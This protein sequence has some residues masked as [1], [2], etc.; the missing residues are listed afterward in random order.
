MSASLNSLIQLIKTSNSIYLF[1]H[2]NGDGDCIGS[3]SALALSLRGIGK[4]CSVVISEDIPYNLD[5]LERGLYIKEPAES[6]ELG[7]LVD[8][9]S[10]NRIKPREQILLNCKSLACIDH[11]EFQESSIKFDAKFVD[12][13][14]AACAEIIYDII[15]ELEVPLDIPLAECIY[16]GIATDTGNFMHSNTSAKSHHIV[17]ELYNIDG[18]D[19]N[20]ICHLI[21]ERVPLKAFKLQGEILTNTEFSFDNQFAF[22]KVS[23]EQLTNSSVSF[24]ELE[25]IVGTLL[26]IQEVNIAAFIKQVS[27]DEFKV[28]LRSKAKFQVS[29]IASSLGGGGHKKAAGYSTNLSFDTLIR[30]LSDLVKQELNH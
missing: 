23:L 14:A 21:Y 29:Q 15:K 8:C 2:I 20:K 3:C 7:I 12:S 5:F 24:D 1:P 6:A 19:A 17:S 11:H 30:E 9:A 27:E 13:S 4:D 28:S 18:F 16:A 25:G 26:S 22:T 10:L